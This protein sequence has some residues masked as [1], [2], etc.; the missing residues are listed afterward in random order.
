MSARA[1]SITTGVVASRRIARQHLEAVEPR[2]HHVEQHE[3]RSLAP[4]A[5]QPFGAVGG[6]VDLE[7]G[8]AQ[9]EGRD[10]PDRGVVLDEQDAGVHRYLPA[11]VPSRS[12]ASSRRRASLIPKWCAISWWTVSMTWARIASG[13]RACCSIVPRK[14]VIRDGVGAQSAPGTLRGTPL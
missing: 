7:P 10:L 9:P 14:I 5:V 12:C 2:Q 6:G 11:W 1:V 8:A 4:P 3:V 13:V